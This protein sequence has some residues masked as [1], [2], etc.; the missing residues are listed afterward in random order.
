MAGLAVVPLFAGFDTES[1]DPDRAGRIVSYDITGGRYEETQG[2]QAV[3]SGSLFAKSSLK[4][5]YDP[6]TDADGAT[7][8][9]IE[10]LYDAADDDSATGG[11]DI[12]RRIFPVVVTITAAEGAVAL[13]DEQT[14]VVAEA[15]VEGRRA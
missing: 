7:R 1:A 10:A 9:A 2:Y 4:K 12:V 5:L 6:D 13:S 8:V 3:G 11:P 15:V 14:A